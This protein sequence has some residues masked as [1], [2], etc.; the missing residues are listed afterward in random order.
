MPW[1]KLDDGFTDHPKVM[2]AGPLASWLFVCGLTYSARMLTDGFIPTTQVRKLADLDNAMA[3]ADRL[4]EVGLWERCDDGFLIHDY[5]E[6]QPSAEKV[7]T[8]R[9]AAQERMQRIRSGEVRANNE[10]SSG[11][12]RPPRTHPVPVTPV[13]DPDPGPDDS[14]G[15]PVGKAKPRKRIPETWALTGELRAY[16]VSHG[17]PESEVDEFAAEFKRYWQGDGRPKAD[18]DLTFMGRVR[19]QAP[20]YKAR[21]NGHADDSKAFAAWDVVL[22]ALEHKREHGTMPAERPDDDALHK[23]VAALGGWGALSG[24][25]FDRAHFVTAYRE[26][27]QGAA[28]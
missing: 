27:K 22:R 10:R 8:E 5:L 6:Y 26:F 7:R 23:A 4:V 18:W 21:M 12:V 28:T 15:A 3:L 13:L 24:D 19:D 20:R 1:A 14:A 11:E 9:K 2:A 17:I 25:R 16:A